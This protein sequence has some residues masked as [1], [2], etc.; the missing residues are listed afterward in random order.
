M[1]VCDSVTSCR[2]H[3]EEAS[4]DTDLQSRLN[5]SEHLVSRLAK[6]CAST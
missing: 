2:K 6:V 5:L 4:G 3:F 1:Y